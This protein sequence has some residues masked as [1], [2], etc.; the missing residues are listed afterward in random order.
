MSI[1]ICNIKN[2]KEEQKLCLEIIINRFSIKCGK[3][4]RKTISLKINQILHGV[5]HSL[6]TYKAFDQCL[7]SCKN[8]SESKY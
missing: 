5:R 8:M 3:F 2:S 4:F 1:L 6:Y 7:S